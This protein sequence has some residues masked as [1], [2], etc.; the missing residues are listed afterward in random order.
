MPLPKSLRGPVRPA[1]STRQTLRK[2]CRACNHLDPRGHTSSVYDDESAKEP[3]ASL[4][5]VVDAL[6]LSRV[7]ES[8]YAFF[9]G[10][11]GARIKVHVDIKEK[12]TIKIT[13]GGERWKNEIA[14]I[15]AGPASR[16][17]WPTL[18]TAHH[19]PINSGSDDTFNFIRRCIQGCIGNP[20]HRAC[21]LSCPSTVSPPKRLLDVGKSASPVRLI[22]THGRHFQY[23]ALSHCWGAH[24]PLVATK[25]NWAKLAVNIAFD[26]FPPLFQDA[27]I[28]TRQLGLRYLWIDSLCIIQDSVRDWET[29]SSK[30]GSIYQNSYVTIATTQSADSS[31][32]CL[33]ERRKPVKIVY[34]NTSGKEFTLR[35][36]KILD[37]HPSHA[38]NGGPAKPV[39]PLTSRAWALQEHVLSTRILHYT[40]TELLFECKTSYRCERMPERKSYPTTPSLIPKAVASKKTDA[41]WQAWQR[42]IEHYTTRHLTVAADKFPA[43]SGIACKI[44]KA[45]HSEYLAGLWKC[46]LASDLLWRVTR[47]AS[48]GANDLALDKWRAPSFSWASL[49]APVTY[50]LLD[51]EERETF[52]SLITIVACKITPVGLNPLG[53]ISDGSVTLRGP[54]IACTLSSHQDHGEWG[55]DVAI[56]GTTPIRM[57]HDC[58][59]A[60]EEVDTSQGEKPQTVRRA[61]ASDTIRHFETPVL[62]LSLARYDSIVAGLVL[63]VSARNHGAWERLGTFAVGTEAAQE[64]EEKEILLV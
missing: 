1:T 57:M 8:A 14:E 46:N 28:I 3:R 56:K 45:T 20:K 11:R 61:R 25:S 43:I 18:G 24:P 19:I 55:Y 35:A 52:K 5:L 36:R 63:G 58:L 12:G 39:G 34:Q 59:L 23:A 40:A 4:S 49:D 16:P 38:P 17:P 13:L 31:A 41:V 29:E 53:A 22:D 47:P 51:E 2:K 60:E 9:S 7:K 27:I 54:T 64:S 30:M 42:I 50:T 10:W 62:C 15:Y 44:R 6:S 21:K 26:V 37:H 33:V 32:R 48:R